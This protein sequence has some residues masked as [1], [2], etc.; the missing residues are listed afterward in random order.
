MTLRLCPSLN[1]IHPHL[2]HLHKHQNVDQ[3]LQTQEAK[4]AL[5]WLAS[6]HA[7]W[8]EEELAAEEEDEGAA[9]EAEAGDGRGAG[10]SSGAAVPAGLWADGCYWHLATRQEELA[11]IG[12]GWAAAL[13]RHAA[14]IDAALR[15]EFGGGDTDDGDGGD[16][17]S[18]S[19]GRTGGSGGRKPGRRRFRTLCHGD[20][21]SA[22]VMFSA[23]GR[24]AAAYDFQYVGFG[25]GAK[26]VAYLLVSS[27]DESLLSDAASERALLSHYGATLRARLRALGKREAAERYTDEI[28]AVHYDLAILDY[29]RFMAGWGFWGAADYA[30]ARAR[31]ALARLPELLRAAEAAARA[32]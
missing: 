6:F 17:G 20:F 10:G 24:A 18:C 21:K 19:G 16:S 27:V 15:G 28:I 1:S 22:N 29:C 3:T 31:S 8:F 12:G 9:A 5:E 26:D 32:P 2:H 4:V 23:D 11:Q 13:K 30:A 7:A 14:A 25:L